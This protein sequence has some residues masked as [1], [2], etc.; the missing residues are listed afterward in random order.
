ML[1]GSLFRSGKEKK[2]IEAT[3]KMTKV[4]I[5]M[6]SPNYEILS[7]NIKINSIKLGKRLG[8]SFV[9]CQLLFGFGN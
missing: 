3:L 5:L 9:D 2:N 4:K 8:F 7:P 1:Y 6:V